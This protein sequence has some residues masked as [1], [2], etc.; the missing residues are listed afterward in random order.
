MESTGQVLCLAGRISLLKQ[1][2][3][4]TTGYFLSQDYNQL[5]I[6]DFLLA[7]S[8]CICEG[9]SAVYF[10][11]IWSTTCHIRILT[12]LNCNFRSI[13]VSVV[14]FIFLNFLNDFYFFQY[15]WFTVFYQ[16]YTV[17]QR[18]P[19]THTYIVF[20]SHYPPS[21]SIISN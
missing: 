6:F 18:D 3:S 13:Y 11:S 14:F 8:W 7:L 5:K 21:F 16:F 15:S 2:S 10:E 9:N 19:V 17:Q 20:F 12:C 4:Y 1:L